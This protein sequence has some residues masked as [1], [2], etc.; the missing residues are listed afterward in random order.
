MDAALAG[1]DAL[2][3]A[4]GHE[5]VPGWAT[6][7]EAL[8][9]TRD[10]LVEHPNGNAWGTRFFVTGDPPEL[11]GWG[12]FKGP[13]KDGVVEVGYEIAE[14][15]RGRGLATAAA[16]AMVAEALADDRVTTVIAHTLP[17]RNASSRVLEK[18]GF[19][20]DGEAAED[21]EVVWRYSLTGRGA[22]QI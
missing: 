15:R 10:A 22:D 20:Y 17:E 3:R 21:G 4:L 2:A 18:V 1:D 12:G 13:P 5:V 6:F 7:T 14:A 16:T 11:V 9:A 19:T 8:P